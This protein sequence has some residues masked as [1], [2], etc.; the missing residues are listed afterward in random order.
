MRG[1][2]QQVRCLCVQEADPPI[3]FL[4]WASPELYV[5]ELFDMD[6]HVHVSVTALFLD[7]DA[8]FQEEALGL[9][10]N[11]E[12]APMNTLKEI[13]EY[14]EDIAEAMDDHLLQCDTCYKHW[15]ED[16]EC[17]RNWH[18]QCKTEDERV[19]LIKRFKTRIRNR[20]CT[21]HSARLP[22][23]QV[24]NHEKIVEKIL[25]IL[26]TLNDEDYCFVMDYV[27][28][29]TSRLHGQGEGYPAFAKQVIKRIY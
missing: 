17:C 4:F 16:Q 18:E 1:A 28:E 10:K 15:Q 12:A 21:D 13:F 14:V 2:I 27:T 11:T 29:G 25:D 22:D 8:S 7:R 20:Y 6:Q 5:A 23:V 19:Q 24:S 3:P 26:K 9:L